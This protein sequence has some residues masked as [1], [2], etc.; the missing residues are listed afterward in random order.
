MDGD[1]AARAAP[2]HIGGVKGDIA[3]RLGATGDHEIV[4]ATGDLHARLD[5][6]LQSRPAA[7]VD[8]HA[9]NRDRQPGVE[10]HHAA[11]GRRLTRRVTM[12]ENDVLHRLGRN[13][14]ALQQA[15]Q[16]RNAQLDR[17]Q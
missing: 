9:G 16:R 13:P 1:A 2:A 7:P 14:V 10:R 5:D 11:D 6:G 12:P 4:C 8:L 3:H 15:P 17:G